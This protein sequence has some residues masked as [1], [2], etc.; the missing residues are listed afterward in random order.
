MSFEQLIVRLV[1]LI[2]GHGSIVGDGLLDVAPALGIVPEAADMS[3]MPIVPILLRASD[4]A[5]PVIIAKSKLMIDVGLE[6]RIVVNDVV[7]RVEVRY[8][9]LKVFPRVALCTALLSFG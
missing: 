3:V 8:D 9:G 6:A 1:E 5:V 7:K 2:E 4:L